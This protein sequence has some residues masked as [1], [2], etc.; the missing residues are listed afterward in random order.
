MM[1]GVDAVAAFAVGSF[2]LVGLAL[3]LFMIVVQPIWCLVDCAVDTQR[4]GGGKAVWIVV[5]VL[6]YGV[7]NWF[8]GALAARG[9]WLRRLTRLAWLFALLLLVGAIA[10][11]NVS[12]G[13]RR[14]I[15]HELQRSRELVVLAAVR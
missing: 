4:S 2:M 12:D 5:L 14:G 13:F 9:A 11:Y 10:L 8:Y 3:M 1:P 6:L 7:A 15:D